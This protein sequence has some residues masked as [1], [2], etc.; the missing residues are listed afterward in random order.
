MK[1]SKLSIA[2]L[3]FTAASSIAQ[4]SKNETKMETTSTGLQYVITEKGNG[5]KAEAGKKVKVHYTGMFLNDTIFDSSVKRNQPFSFT[6]GQGQVIKGWDEGI[7]LLKEGDKATLI[8]PPALGYGDRQTGPIPANST[9][10]FNVE[11]LEV[12]D[13]FFNV[14]GKEIVSTSSGLK[15]ISVEE[16]KGKK[17]EKNKVVSV[18]YTGF[19]IDENGTN[20]IFDSSVD[21]G[22]PI[23]FT[24]GSGMVIKG[25][26]E[27]IELMKVGDKRRLIIPYQLGYGENGMPPVIPAKA[28]LYFDVELMDVK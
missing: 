1:K 22:Q 18:H 21:R 19:T 15:Y 12:I 4:N 8:I 17:A 9:L 25:W 3:L 5:K 27:G 23:E 24:L 13:P 10:K 16:G 26:E 11:L 6:L 2:I 20:K 14:S 28:T 7:A